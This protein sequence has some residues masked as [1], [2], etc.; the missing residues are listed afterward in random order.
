VNPKD[1]APT[2]TIF[3]FAEDSKGQKFGNRT[4]KNAVALPPL[5]TTQVLAFVFSPFTYADF[6]PL[7]TDGGFGL[8]IESGENRL[9]LVMGL[10]CRHVYAAGSDDEIAFMSEAGQYFFRKLFERH[11]GSAPAN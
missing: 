6:H 7:C 5:D 9:D 4:V 10:F 2:V 11:F 8:R 1:G 3:E